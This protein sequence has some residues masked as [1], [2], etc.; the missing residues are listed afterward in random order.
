MMAWEMTA[1]TEPNDEKISFVDRILDSVHGYIELTQIE[2]KIIELPIFKRLQSIKQ[3]SLVNFV[4]PGAEHTRYTHSLGVMFLVD[5]MAVQLNFTDGDRQL[6]RLAGLLHDIGHYPLSHVGESV[7]SSYVND[8]E[9]NSEKNLS[10]IELH[11]N[12]TLEDIERVGKPSDLNSGVPQDKPYHHEAIGAS[13][14]RHSAEIKELIS[15]YCDYINFEYICDIITGIYSRYPQLSAMI[16][17]MHSELDADRIDYLLRDASFSGTNYGTVDIGIIIKNLTGEKQHGVDIIGIKPK[18]ISAADQFLIN[19]FF[20]KSQIICN[21]H[22]SALEFMA[23]AI[24]HYISERGIFGFPKPDSLLK[25]VDNYEKNRAFLKF[26]DHLFWSAIYKIDESNDYI[27][28]PRHVVDFARMLAKHREIKTVSGIDN[29][30]SGLEYEKL[31]DSVYGSQPYSNL[32]FNSN[33]PFDMFQ[34][35]HFT[36]EV[37]TEVT[38]FIQKA[39]IITLTNDIPV[40]IHNARLVEKYGDSDQYKINE[41]IACK[42]YRLQDGLAVI[43][44]KDGLPEIQ[45]LVDDTRSLIK[46]LFEMRLIILREYDLFQYEDEVDTPA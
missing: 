12:R 38:Y 37:D 40:D 18:G 8:S 1:V 46:T 34:P 2:R 45:L 6:I 11:T 28:H 27:A 42:K 41:Q 24:I 21:R 23:Q 31:L 33:N 5:K 43:D 10:F 7:Y 20:A 25:Y 9:H 22:V 17:L 3:L 39:H 14:I 19:R 16:Q 15:K 30:Y 13:I 35:G 44:N 29:T 36:P 32:Q 4:F 26:T